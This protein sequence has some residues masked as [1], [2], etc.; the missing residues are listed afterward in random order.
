MFFFTAIIYFTELFLV[1]VFL[2][3]KN[4]QMV[5]LRENSCNDQISAELT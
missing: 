3:L 2:Y 5:R 4:I 1:I